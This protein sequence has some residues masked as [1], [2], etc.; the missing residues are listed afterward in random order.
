M[1]CVNEKL[2]C[3]GEIHGYTVCRQ[4]QL[5]GMTHCDPANCRCYMDDGSERPAGK[6]QVEWVRECMEIR[7]AVIDAK[8]GP[9]KRHL[10]SFCEDAASQTPCDYGTS[11]L[12]SDT[13]IAFLEG[14]RRTPF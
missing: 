13:T 6:S 12:P 1:G 5:S 9:F 14:K 10:D 8:L 2:T 7:N 4:F 3:F 11:T